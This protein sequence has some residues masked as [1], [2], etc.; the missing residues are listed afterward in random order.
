[1]VFLLYA[2][3]M[4]FFFPCWITLATI[5]KMWILVYSAHKKWWK[6]VGVIMK[7][8]P[9]TETVQPPDSIPSVSEGLSK[10]EFLEMCLIGLG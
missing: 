6:H 9:H 7:Y 5:L 4:L 10:L 8:L 2:T 1:M 3:S